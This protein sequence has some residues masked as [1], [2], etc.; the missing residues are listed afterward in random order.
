MTFTVN[1]PIK[2]SPFSAAIF[3]L[4]PYYFI[5]F[6]LDHG[7]ISRK[8]TSI[9]SSNNIFLIPC[10][11]YRYSWKSHNF[12]FLVRYIPWWDYFYIPS[13]GKSLEYS[14]I[15]RDLL[16]ISPTSRHPPPRP[17]TAKHRRARVP[18][19]ESW[20]NAGW[21]PMVVPKS[22]GIPKLAG[23]IIS[24]TIPNVNSWVNCWWKFIQDGAP[25][26]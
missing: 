13:D 26:L 11:P 8:N 18:P 10:Y 15:P 7:D 21:F 24:W 20:R 19:G 2:M 17:W 12:R 16:G 4:Y 25:Q 5:C 14:N 1:C 9:C 23:G 22:W 3:Q 6:I